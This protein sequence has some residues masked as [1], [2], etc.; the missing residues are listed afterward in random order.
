MKT[1]DIM[2]Y[3][4]DYYQLNKEKM[5]T[6]HREYYKTNRDR[7]MEYQINYYNTHKEQ[8]AIYNKNVYIPKHKKEKRLK[9]HLIIRDPN[10][11]VNANPFID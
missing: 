2:Q 6:Y 8:Y 11:P 10:K 3:R 1:A 5:K 7:L 9:K 4:K